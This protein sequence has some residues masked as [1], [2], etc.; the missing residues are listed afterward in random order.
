MFLLAKPMTN[1]CMYGIYIY[2]LP[3]TIKKY[4]SFVS[5][6]LPYIRIRHG[7]ESCVF[8]EVPYF[9]VVEVLVDTS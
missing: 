1:P 7:K 9:H 5:I 4:P 8:A 3:L 6:N 2:G